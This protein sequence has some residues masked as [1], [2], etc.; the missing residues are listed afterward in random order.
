MHKF[1]KE[2]AIL[3]CQYARNIWSGVDRRV[4]LLGVTSKMFAVSSLSY[5]SQ[6]S[7]WCLTVLVTAIPLESEARD[8]RD[9]LDMLKNTWNEGARLLTSAGEAVYDLAHPTEKSILNKMA[10]MTKVSR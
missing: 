9:V 5:H 4:S 10:D 7:P 1:V 8:K 6:H 2:E 3:Y